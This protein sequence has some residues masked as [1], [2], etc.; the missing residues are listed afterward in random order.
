MRVKVNGLLP[1]QQPTSV[2]KHI[3][4]IK[5]VHNSLHYSASAYIEISSALLCRSCY[6]IMRQRL[7][8][9]SW[10][11]YDCCVLVF[12]TSYTNI[13]ARRLG[14]NSVI[15][16]SS[17]PL[18]A[19]VLSLTWC[20]GDVMKALDAVNLSVLS[21]LAV[22]MVTMCLFLSLHQHLNVHQGAYFLF[23]TSGEVRDLSKRRNLSVWSMLITWN[24]VCLGFSFKKNIQC[25]GGK[26]WFNKTNRGGK[27][28]N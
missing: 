9:V 10:L 25:R 1:C 28:W 13:M 21:W 14:G 19:V 5:I 12:L 20:A 23:L 7:G 16:I 27:E 2:C 17:R 6:W 24:N 26:A 11:D 15:Q 4:F 3:R 22:P 8:P 18:A